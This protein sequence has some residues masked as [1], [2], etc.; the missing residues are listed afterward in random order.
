MMSK[1][2]Q[3]LSLTLVVAILVTSLGQLTQVKAASKADPTV[4]SAEKK[5]V[6]VSPRL[7]RGTHQSDEW[8]T[9][10]VELNNFRSGQF[11]SFLKRNGVRLE[12]EMKKLRTFS[13]KVPFSLVPEL[14]AFPEVF[15]VSANAPVTPVGHV[16]TTTGTDAGRTEAATAGRGTMDGPGGGRAMRG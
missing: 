15:H 14:A 1:S 10:I 8:V 6:K 13:I 11:N 16:S 12:R 2:S 7:A 5:A 9:V 3:F 4:K